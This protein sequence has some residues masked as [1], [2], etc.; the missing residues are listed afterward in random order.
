MLLD[1]SLPLSL[2]ARVLLW[3]FWSQIWCIFP[4]F[5]CLCVSCPFI[6]IILRFSAT[7]SSSN[8][9]SILVI[10]SPRWLFELGQLLALRQ[11]HFLRFPVVR[12]ALYRDSIDII[13]IANCWGMGT[14]LPRRNSISF[15]RCLK[16][17][18]LIFIGSIFILTEAHFG[19][20]HHQWPLLLLARLAAPDWRFGHILLLFAA[21]RLF[22][23]IIVKIRWNCLMRSS[24]H[25]RLV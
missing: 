19:V 23:H 3:G 15:N 14:E 17:F 10:V 12:G 18:S 13:Y 11:G 1:Q 2:V 8:S 22:K 25:W 4:W 21:V 7:L 16:L 9:W 6:W 5:T 24:I 20:I